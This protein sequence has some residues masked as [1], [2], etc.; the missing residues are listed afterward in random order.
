MTATVPTVPLRDQLAAV[1][2]SG[3]LPPEGRDVMARTFAYIA[4]T[5]PGLPIG[6]RAPGFTL[7][8]HLGRSVSLAQRLATGP[9]VLMF[10]RGA[11]CPY[12]NVALRAMNAILE[13]LR[14]LDASLLAI[15]PQAADHTLPLVEKHRLGF[16]VLSDE[17]QRVIAA[18][19]LGYQTP[20]EQQKLVLAALNL[21]VGKEN[22][23][24]TW[25]L[26][27]TATYVLDQHGTIVAGRVT[28]NPR[29]R[30]EPD[31]VI[32]ALLQLR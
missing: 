21:D 28:P 20:P 11:W 13:R 29:E 32:I 6:T 24:G 1:S 17:R 14:Q 22:A 30:M 5:A 12:C 15:S 27:A 8:D 4:A 3:S 18:Y 9:V 31:D 10:Y 25:K 2:G 19:R 23:D 16:D 7:P 26:P